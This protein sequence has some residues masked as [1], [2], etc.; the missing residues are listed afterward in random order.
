MFAALC[1]SLRPLLDCF[2]QQRYDVQIYSFLSFYIRTAASGDFSVSFVKNPK[3][4]PL[5]FKCIHTLNGVI[6]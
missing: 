6:Q 4:K 5:N 2:L 1:N 3:L